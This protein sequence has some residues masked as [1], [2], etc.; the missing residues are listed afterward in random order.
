MFSSSILF[1]HLY[2]YHFSVSLHI[3]Y[4]KYT[5]YNNNLCSKPQTEKLM[6]CNITMSVP[7]FS[8]VQSLSR[9]QLFATPWTPARQVSLS[10]IDSLSLLKLV[11]IESVMPFNHLILSSPFPPAFPFS[12]C[13]QSFPE[14]GSFPMSQFFTWPKSVPSPRLTAGSICKY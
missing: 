2:I 5:F 8:S 13:L 4:C 11:S 7:Q 14:S 10:I 6:L 9:V 12:S 3:T 1:A